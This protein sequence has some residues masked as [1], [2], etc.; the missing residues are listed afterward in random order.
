MHDVDLS[1]QFVQ[2]SAFV[3]RVG[4]EQVRFQRIFVFEQ[5]IAQIQEALFEVA[6]VEILRRDAIVS[7]FPYILRE[8][9]AKVEKRVLRLRSFQQREDTRVA[10]LE[11]NGE[12]EESK[13]ADA[14]IGL[15]GPCSFPLQ[16]RQVSCNIIWKC[17]DGQF[18]GYEE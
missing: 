8:A 16:A 5:I 13:A 18:Q 3:E 7:E 11:G 15:E 14:R 10:W 2:R 4:Y 9:A 12:V 1:L 17:L 6:G